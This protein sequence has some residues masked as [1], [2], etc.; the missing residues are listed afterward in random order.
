MVVNP[1]LQTVNAASIPNGEPLS[2]TLMQATPLSP[3]ANS[4]RGELTQAPDAVTD[5]PNA[6]LHWDVLIFAIEAAARHEAERS[7]DSRDFELGVTAEKSEPDS[8]PDTC[9]Y[10]DSYLGT[11]TGG[12]DGCGVVEPGCFCVPNFRPTLPSSNGLGF[13]NISCRRLI[14]FPW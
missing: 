12:E 6:Y 3:Q 14:L 1:P 4:D 9:V 13:G 10:P 2:G 11:L 8:D 7:F 5:I